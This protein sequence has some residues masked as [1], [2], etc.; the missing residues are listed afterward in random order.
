MIEIYTGRPGGGKTY[1]AVL[2]V[3]EYL[4]NGGHV[5]SNVPFNRDKLQ[6]FI[7]KEHGVT[8]DVEAQLQL[9]SF[10][11]VYRFHRIVPPGTPDL[12]TLVVLDEIQL[13][14]NSR[15]MGRDFG[16]GTF[17]D[18]GP[19]LPA[20]PGADLVGCAV[21]M[22]QGTPSEDRPRRK[23]GRNPQQA[24]RTAYREM[25]EFL[26]QHRH[27]HM[28]LIFI[29]Q[30][31]RNI[32]VQMVRL[33]Q[34]IWRFRDL[35]KLLIPWLGIAYP[36]PQFLGTAFDYD[37]KTRNGPIRFVPK[38]KDVFALYSSYAWQRPLPMLDAK[39]RAAVASARGFPWKEMAASLALAGTLVGIGCARHDQAAVVAA[40]TEVRAM[41][42]AMRESAAVMPHSVEVARSVKDRKEEWEGIPDE[43][44][45]T[46]TFSHPEPVLCDGVV[47]SGGRGVLYGVPGCDEPV[48]VGDEICGARVLTIGLRD[49]VLDYGR[50]VVRHPLRV[51]RHERTNEVPS[52]VAVS[53]LTFK[54][55]L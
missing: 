21:G 7:Q 11:D 42:K 53:P 8:V 34:N 50:S 5:A 48:R 44:R 2:K 30:H 17:D 51:V 25:M 22:G 37:G 52:A 43:Y 29:T 20:D 32:D 46:A 47:M 14:F 19:V 54:A 4:A 12:P 45:L 27:A 33:M 10:A 13:Q 24:G 28:D 40:A 36:I 3:C 26:T 41:A 6:A 16:G 1:A 38:R 49:I 15:D 35:Q 31:E 39:A 55:S 18:D 23:G 9:L